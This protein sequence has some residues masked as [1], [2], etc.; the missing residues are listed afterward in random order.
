MI[1]I[2]VR[3]FSQRASGVDAVEL[4]DMAI[5]K[6]LAGRNSFDIYCCG[7]YLGSG[8]PKRLRP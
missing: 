3:V 8:E 1:R 2:R 7:G 6:R 4:V 5:L